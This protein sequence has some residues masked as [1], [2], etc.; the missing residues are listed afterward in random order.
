MWLLLTDPTVGTSH[1]SITD[2]PLIEPT[3]LSW[4][5]GSTI[6]V[7]KGVEVYVKVSEEF[8]RFQRTGLKTGLLAEPATHATYEAH[9]KS[10]LDTKMPEEYQKYWQI[11]VAPPA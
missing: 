4:T 9:G 10:K 2:A 1:P 3:L 6:P 8:L 7:T 5:T 11:H